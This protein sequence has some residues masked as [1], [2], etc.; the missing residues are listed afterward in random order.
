MSFWDRVQSAV[1]LAGDVMGVA[2]DL[3]VKAAEDLGIPMDLLSIGTGAAAA[4]EKGQDTGDVVGGT[5]G[6]FIGGKLGDFVATPFGLLT[7]AIDGVANIVGASEDTKDVTGL[8]ADMAPSNFLQDITTLVGRGVGNL[9]TGDSE[10]IDK[11][12][13]E[14]REGE[15]GGPLQGLAMMGNFICDV[16]TGDK[17]AEEAVMSAGSKG[18]DSILGKAGSW[19]GDVAFDL[20]HDDEGE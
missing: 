7:E 18:E 2:G 12:G 15:H 14:V 11:L 16:V 5:A 6:E 3:G 10:G 4:A 8:A 17:G 9:V 1:D 19:L 20:L 13:D